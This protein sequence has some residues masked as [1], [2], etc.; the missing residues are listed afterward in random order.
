MTRLLVVGGEHP[1]AV[2]Q[3]LLHASLEHSFV[4]T[5]YYSSDRAI[6]KV[7]IWQS[8]LWRLAN[9]RPGRLNRFNQEL[10]SVAAEHKPNLIIS[11]GNLPMTNE[12]LRSLVVAGAKTYLYSTDDPWNPAHYTSR[13][14]RAI[15]EYDRVFTT[16][17]A[18]MTEF[19]NLGVAVEHLQFGYDPRYFYRVESQ[20]HPS[21]ELFFA[22]GGDKERVALVSAV[23]N[24]GIALHLY[25]GLWGRW[26]K[27]AKA[28]KGYANPVNLSELISSAR[29]NL[30][31]V[32]R[33]N[34]DGTSMRSFELGACGACIVAE[35]TE[36]HHELYGSDGEAVRYFKS[37]EQLIQ[38]TR[39]LLEDEGQRE[40]LSA[41]AYK[42]ITTG[43]H[44]YSDRL[45]TLIDRSVDTECC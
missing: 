26:P 4:D 17:K 14:Q 8:I 18:N 44:K 43:G 41:A 16:R 28:Y 7:R 40:K 12:T 45:R 25:G 33:A 29:V 30:C 35:D 27:T 42:T 22:G 36:E 1:T 32:R 19:Q 21:A 34:R 23:L 2:G 10:R 38:V 11:A 5:R 20:A 9:K 13:F 37:D 39:E 6:S 3:S 24:A 31:L 15:P